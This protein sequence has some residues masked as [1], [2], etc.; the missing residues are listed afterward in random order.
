MHV[1]DLLRTA[2]LNLWRRKLRAVLTVLGLVIGVASIVVMMSLGIGIK[3]SIMDSYASMGSLYNITVSSWKWVETPNGGSGSETKLDKKAVAAIRSLPGVRAAMPMV[4]TGGIV[5]SGKWVS[6]VSILAVS[7]EDAEMFDIKLDEGRFPSYK[8]GSNTYEI[9]VGQE[10]LNW[11]YDPKTGR[12][13]QDRDGNPRVTKDSRMQITF[14]Y[15]NVYGDNLPEGT[16]LGS[17]Y[18]LE[19]V[20]M[21]SPDNNEF[22]WYCF[23]SMEAIEKLAREN[24]DFMHLNLD[25][26]DR[27]QVK[28]DS[29]DA[30]ESVKNAISDMG[31]GTSSLKDAIEQA[32]QQMQ[33]IEYLLG[34]IGGVSLLVAA[35][36]I[37][38]TMM[39]SIYERTREIGIMKVL[40]CRM[41]NI[42]S[43]FLA[44]AGF[45]GL[46]GGGLGLGASF[47]LSSLIN[48]LAAD[49]GFA[50]VIPLWLALGGVAFS[51][52]VA[53][54]SGLYP[55]MRAMRL[56]PL[57]AIRTE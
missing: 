3:Q 53:L 32:E 8:R 23:M 46:F 30:V 10:M 29:L 21:N 54:L 45:I 26:Y 52:V 20:G 39:M 48:T 15:N 55:A 57:N 42:V 9:V 16:T 41:S 12:P 17:W 13:A 44:E 35:I 36:G 7:A 34:A 14:D 25:T 6:D 11:F 5:K 18:R 27:V 56:S 28:C 37:M 4:Q 31:Y 22:S 33:Q 1:S 2:F 43:L 49:N 40:G 51:I 19:T 47:G 24:K 38:N 50:S